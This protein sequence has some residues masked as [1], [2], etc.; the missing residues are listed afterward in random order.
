MDIMSKAAKYDTS[1][2]QQVTIYDQLPYQRNIAI[3]GDDCIR[4]ISGNVVK[5]ATYKQQDPKE[6]PNQ[7]EVILERIREHQEIEQGNNS[8]NEAL[9]SFEE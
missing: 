1:L 6:V 4:A 9:D 3:C 8:E 7:D 5:Y 2:E